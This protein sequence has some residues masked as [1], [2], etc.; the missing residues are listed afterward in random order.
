MLL[1]KGIPKVSVSMVVKCLAQELIGPISRKPQKLFGPAKLF[2]VICILKTEK[3][4]G[5]KLCMKRSSVHT[6]NIMELTV[7]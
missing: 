5:L 7:L 3:C 1:T 4:I 6:K 2:F